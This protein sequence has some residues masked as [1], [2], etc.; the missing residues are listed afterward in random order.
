MSPNFLS[1]LVSA[2][3]L[4]KNIGAPDLKI[5]DC[6]WRLASGS[7]EAKQDFLQAHIPGAVFFDIDEICDPD[8]DL[9]HTLPS[10][11][12]FAEAVGD[13]GISEND[14]VVIYDQAGLFSAPRG[15]WTFRAMGHERVAVLNGGLP[16]WKAIN[17]DIS[18]DAVAPKPTRYTHPASVNKLASHQDIR[19]RSEGEAILDARPQ[20]RFTGQAPEPRKGLHSGAIPR[21][22]NLPVSDVI[23]ENGHLLPVESLINLFDGLKIGN[24]P[25]ITTCGSGVAAAT[26]AL[27]LEIT[28]HHNWRVYDGSWSEWGRTSNDP[29]L[30]PVVA[31]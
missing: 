25:V 3:W 2:D 14:T 24:S 23:D 11:A 7:R 9:P 19:A 22:L 30:F 18:A 4:K 5:I 17:G 12:I 20:N 31:T 26:L 6:S 1:P 13:L 28:G 10:P 21:S 15:W 27:A 8:T 29:Q 16:A